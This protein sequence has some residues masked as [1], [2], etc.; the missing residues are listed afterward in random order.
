MLLVPAILNAVIISLRS[1]PDLVEAVGD[2]QSIAAYDDENSEYRSEADAVNQ[3]PVPSILV[4]HEAT[5]MRAGGSDFP[6]WVH[7][8]RVYFRFER[9]SEAWNAIDKLINGVPDPATGETWMA[10]DLLDKLYP[11]S[12]VAI[13]YTRNDDGTQLSVLSCQYVE[14]GG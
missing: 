4:C 1:I 14:I 8:V 7:G 13:G 12:D 10:K 11:P 6:R 5:E 9:S 3:M 2:A